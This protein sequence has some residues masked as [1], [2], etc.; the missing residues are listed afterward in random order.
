[1]VHRDYASN[2]PIVF[3]NPETLYKQHDRQPISQS[4]HNNKPDHNNNNNN[5]NREKK[6]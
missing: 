5:K 6:R 1:M 4:A 2:Q 3:I